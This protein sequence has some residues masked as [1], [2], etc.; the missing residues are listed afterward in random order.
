[1]RRGGGP[2]GVAVEMSQDFQASFTEAWTH[3]NYS[4]QQSPGIA[5]THTL[6]CTCTPA[7]VETLIRRHNTASEEGN[8]L[9]V[10]IIYTN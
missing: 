5:T 2:G 1:M 6:I 8:E 4:H 3:S 7:D 9:S 10:K